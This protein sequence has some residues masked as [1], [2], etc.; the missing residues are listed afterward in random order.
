MSEQ[1]RE[2]AREALRITDEQLARCY[3]MQAL[4]ML[5]AELGA[6][7]ENQTGPKENKTGPQESETAPAENKTTASRGNKTAPAESKITTPAVASPTPGAGP[8]NAGAPLS[9]AAEELTRPFRLNVKRRLNKKYEE[10]LT[11]IDDPAARKAELE[12]LYQALVDEYRLL[13]ARG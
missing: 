1:A 13:L 3:E 2:T 4:E 9:D 8:S 11:A 5:M 7:P 12:A 10:V 6:L